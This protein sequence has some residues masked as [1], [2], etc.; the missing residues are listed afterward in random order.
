MSFGKLA[1]K[2]GRIETQVVFSNPVRTINDK[3]HFVSV[4]FVIGEDLIGQVAHSD[5]T[6][7]TW[8]RVCN[9]PTTDFS[10]VFAPGTSTALAR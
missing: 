1:N 6:I 5:L 10:G 3:P 8:F 2:V 9:G 4:V 7:Q